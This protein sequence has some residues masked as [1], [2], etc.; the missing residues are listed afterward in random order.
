MNA[1]ALFPLLLL[2]AFYFLVLRP[3]QRRV[4]AHHALIDTLGIGDRVVTAGGLVGTIV[5]SSTDRFEVQLAP[6]V[7]VEII[8]G[9]IAQK[10]PAEITE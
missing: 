7:V 5:G 1:S 2:G 8:K 6:S 4:R 10:V 9:A 3:Q